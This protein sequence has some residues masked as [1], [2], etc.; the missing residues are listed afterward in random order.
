MSNFFK[1]KVSEFYFLIITLFYWIDISKIVNQI[2]IIFS[3]LLLYLIFRQKKVMGLIYGGILFSLT[4]YLSLAFLSDFYKITEF[5]LKDENLLLIV[6]LIM[7]L[8]MIYKYSNLN[9][10]EKHKKVVLK[11]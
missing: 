11:I 3:T 5:N 2:A 9:F 8:F 7:S 6:N 10:K 1:Y 4:F